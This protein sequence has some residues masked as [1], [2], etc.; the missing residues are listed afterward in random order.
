MSILR[1]VAEGAQ[2]D[3]LK[4]SNQAIF[5][6]VDVVENG[7]VQLES[8]LTQSHTLQPNQDFINSFKLSLLTQK[9]ASTIEH[10]L[11]TNK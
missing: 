11:K 10:A 5:I 8:A 2:K 3:L 4:E 9:L 6:D 1:F 7:V